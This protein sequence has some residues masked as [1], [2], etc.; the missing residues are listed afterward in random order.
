[1][2]ID[3]RTMVQVQTLGWS[4]EQAYAVLLFCVDLVESTISRVVGFEGIQGWVP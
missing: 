4:R 1:M 3:D 2:T